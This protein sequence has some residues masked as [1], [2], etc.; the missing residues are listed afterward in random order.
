MATRKRTPKRRKYTQQRRAEQ[1]SETRRRIVE[2]V[3]AL[4]GEVGPARTSIKAIAERADVERLTVYR[5]FADEGEIFAACNAHFQAETPPPDP[6]AWAGVADP[7]ARLRAAL[8]AFYRYYRGG[9]DMLANALRDAPELPALAA[10]MAPFGRLV[11]ATREDL[12]AAWPARGRVRTRLTAA[13]GHALRFDTWR[14]LAHAEGLD[15][16]GAA[17]LMVDLARAAAAPEA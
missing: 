5:H 10:V 6:A 4:H 17:D 11:E 3:A 13:I 14:S 2:A 8:L 12:R 16:A 15:D 7:A 1:Q 9:G